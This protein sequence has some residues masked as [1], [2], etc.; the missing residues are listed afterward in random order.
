MGVRYV[1][2]RGLPEFCPE[3]FSNDDQLCEHIIVY[4]DGFFIDWTFRQYIKDASFPTIYASIEPLL[5]H[6]RDIT[7]TT[8]LEYEVGKPERCVG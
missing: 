8:C 7:F 3:Y 5:E 6:W 1:R 4:A 2:L